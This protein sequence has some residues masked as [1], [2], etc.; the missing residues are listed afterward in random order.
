MSEEL[1]LAYYVAIK[2]SASYLG[3]LLMTNSQGIPTDFRYTEPITPT[4]LQSVLYGKALEPHLKGEVIQ[5][6]LMKE[7]KAPPDLMFVQ[8]SELSSDFA[9]DASCPILSA[10]RSQE[11][12]LR[13]VG[14][15]T[16]T[17]SRELLVQVG[18]GGHPLRIIFPQGVAEPDQEAVLQKVIEA[19]YRMD[20]VEPMERAL[21]ALRTLIQR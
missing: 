2:E 8:A 13:E 5:K 17:S 19:G 10:Q 15:T 14:A 6:A 20:L 11:P 4:K 3:G 21:E 9:A 7:I 18:E 1:R 12:P 16:R